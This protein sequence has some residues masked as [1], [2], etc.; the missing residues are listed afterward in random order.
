VAAVNVAKWI[1]TARK[2]TIQYKLVMED[3]G[4]FPQ[5]FA[6]LHVVG[7]LVVGFSSFDRAPNKTM[8]EYDFS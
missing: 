1:G 3:M 4:T 8:E 6:F 2:K 5:L 7:T